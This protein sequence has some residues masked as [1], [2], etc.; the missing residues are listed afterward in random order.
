MSCWS[1]WYGRAPFTPPPPT[2]LV[3]RWRTLRDD[4]VA[5]LFS[6]DYALDE[7]RGANKK[8][9]PFKVCAFTAGKASACLPMFVFA[10]MQPGAAAIT[11][12]RGAGPWN[13]NSKHAMT[14]MHARNVRRPQVRQS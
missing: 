5:S 7:V 8:N 10:C 9:D 4:V 13:A 6:Q 1:T 12:E 14:V 2:H 11:V 3:S